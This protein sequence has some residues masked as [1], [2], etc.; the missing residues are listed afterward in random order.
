MAET[1]M[2]EGFAT[3]VE[4]AWFQPKN[5][6]RVMQSGAAARL[7]RCTL[8]LEGD[9]EPVEL[10]RSK[11]RYH[12]YTRQGLLFRTMPDAIS[13]AWPGHMLTLRLCAGKENGFIEARHFR[14]EH[15]THIFTLQE[16]GRGQ[17]LQGRMPGRFWKN[18]SL[19]CICTP[20]RPKPARGDQKIVL[21]PC[22][23]SLQG[24][25][26]LGTISCTSNKITRSTQL[27]FHR[28][29][30]TMAYVCSER[31]ACVLRIDFVL[32]E[33]QVGLCLVKSLRK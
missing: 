20:G 30:C 6:T 5:K 3:A 4:T 16:G 22:R 18:H 19:D 21:S 14:R 17:E 15:L 32:E 28:L 8:D 7:I 27:K 29:L 33:K 2:Q 1:H 12:R 13:H 9:T 24:P 31:S 26:E 25:L 10:H 11:R 23:C